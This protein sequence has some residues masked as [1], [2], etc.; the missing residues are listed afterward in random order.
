MLVEAD[1]AQDLIAA[2]QSEP[3]G[4]VRIACPIDLLHAH[5]GRMLVSFALAHPSVKV[6]LVGVNRAVDLVAEGLD[7]A[8][9]VRPLPLEDSD[10][11]MRVLG[12][13]TQCLV[14]SPALVASLGMPRAPQICCHGRA[15]VMAPAWKAITGPCWALMGPES[16]STT[17]PLCHHRH[18]D[19]AS[20][21]IDGLGVVQLPPP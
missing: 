6:Q 5:V 1:A 13:A 20:G 7:M 21:A 18:A 16:N 10:L 14:A 9:R 12:Y 4:L 11:A 8:L 19:I 2:T 3:C 15:S 17:A